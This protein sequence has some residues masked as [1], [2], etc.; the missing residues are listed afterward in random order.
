MEEEEEEEEDKEEKNKSGGDGTMEEFCEMK[1]KL[2]TS[3][4]KITSLEQDIEYACEQEDYERAAELE[5]E[6]ANVKK[7]F[8]DVQSEIENLTSDAK[9][10]LS[11]IEARIERAVNE[12]EDYELAAKLEEE[13]VRAESIVRVFLSSNDGDEKEG[14]APVDMEEERKESESER[15]KEEEEEEEEIVKKMGGRG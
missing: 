2:E 11:D 8:Q 12:D 7:T 14:E 9:T 10:L 15:N 4:K 5:T 1:S 6:L 13:K 3:E